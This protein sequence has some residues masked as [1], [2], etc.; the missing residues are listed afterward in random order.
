LLIGDLGSHHSDIGTD[1][2]RGYAIADSIAPF[3]V[4]ND[5]DSKGAWAFTLLHELTH[6]W[7]GA[8]GVSNSTVWAESKLEK[9]CNDVASEILL[10]EG[11]IESLPVS[12]NSAQDEVEAVIQEFSQVAKLSNT[13][14]AYNLYKANKLTWEQYNHLS[15]KFRQYWI[16]NKAVNK[17]KDGTGPTYT[18]IRRHRL[19]SSIINFV[20]RMM[21]E[22]ALT[23]TKAAKI[24][25]VKPHNLG[26]ILG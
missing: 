19:G 16:D 15:Q 7:L 2:F 23:P 3:I 22:G 4:I 13:M 24:L 8:E 20:G 25:G 26:Q 5:N 11:E 12:P 10:G 6:L 18:V 17:K 21:R 9:F 1:I 14:V